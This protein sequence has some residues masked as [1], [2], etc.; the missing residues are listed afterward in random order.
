MPSGRGFSFLALPFGLLTFG[1]LG[2][3]RRSRCATALPAMDNVATA[4][5]CRQPLPTIA[6]GRCCRGSPLLQN[7]LRQKHKS[8]SNDF[9]K[10]VR[11]L[12]AL[13][14]ARA[15][16]RLGR[17]GHCEPGGMCCQAAPSRPPAWPGGS[18]RLTW[19]RRQNSA[20]AP[21]ARQGGHVLQHEREGRHGCSPPAR[22]HPGGGRP[23]L[24]RP[25]GSADACST[26]RS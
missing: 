20:C 2:L 15:R 13:Q 24:C 1:A 26:L 10:T 8:R 3:I 11:V 7:E 23:S 21:G 22:H 12:P 25:G 19:A 14:F 16:P 4:C 6:V 18:Q 5:T 17:H 9:P